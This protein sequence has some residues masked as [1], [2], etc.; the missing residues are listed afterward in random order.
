MADAPS[1]RGSL[2]DAVHRA[3]LWIAY[4]LL[5]AAWFVFRPRRRG[6]FVAVWHDG[7]I[8]LIR[9]SYRA[10]VT[11]PAGGLWRGETPEDAALRELQEEVGLTASPDALRFAREI[12][13]RFEYKRDRCSFFELRLAAPI[14]PLVD[15]REVIW[16][17]FVPRDDA[18][19]A[20]LVPPVRVYL[21]EC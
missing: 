3:G 11:L 13:S 2:V 8:L 18:L 17:A 9:N 10:G 12:P 19:R 15:R 1:P 14:E 7:R 4:R 20:P 5:L 6:V 21:E 16:A